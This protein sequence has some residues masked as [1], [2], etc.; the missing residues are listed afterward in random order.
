MK[1]YIYTIFC[2]THLFFAISVKAEDIKS[3]A[4]E[5]VYEGF[6]YLDRLAKN[7]SEM[8][9]GNYSGKVLSAGILTDARADCAFVGRSYQGRGFSCGF[10][11]IE[12]VRGSC[13]FTQNEKDTI[14]AEWNCITSASATGDARCEGKASFVNGT[15]VYSA[16]SG[17][18]KFHAPLVTGLDREESLV[19]YWD[20]EVTLPSAINL[21]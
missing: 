7:D 12:N 9:W 5:I 6:P 20:G 3:I 8:F 21:Q 2:L 4:L 16:I 19:A 17:V 18:V 10:A 1:V 11:K 13:I 15:G 14:I